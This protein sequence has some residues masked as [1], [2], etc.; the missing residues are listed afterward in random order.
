M[1]YLN[2]NTKKAKDFVRR[3]ENATARDIYDAYKNPSKYKAMLY[4]GI[5]KSDVYREQKAHNN[6]FESDI[7]FYGYKIIGANCSYFTVARLMNV[8][9]KKTGELDNIWLVVD[10]PTRQYH[11]MLGLDYIK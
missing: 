10:T 1:E 9:D 11:I 5:L 4:I 2:S 6:P 8:I 7:D 3:Y